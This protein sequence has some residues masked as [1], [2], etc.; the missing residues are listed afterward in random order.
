MVHSQF[1]ILEP[2]MPDEVDV[3]SIDVRRTMDEVLNEALSK[4][5]NTID[6]DV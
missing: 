3:V 2:P 4:V 6:S 1:D 5:Q